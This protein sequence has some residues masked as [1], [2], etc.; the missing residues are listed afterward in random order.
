MVQNATFMIPAS[1]FWPLISLMALLLYMSFITFGGTA[2]GD[3]RK[4]RLGG[5]A[6]Y[7][8]N[9]GI[10]GFFAASIPSSS[11]EYHDLTAHSDSSDG[12]N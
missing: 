9:R 5:R 3:A 2:L 6:A 4:P 1:Y 8:H 11:H 10:G 7:W 12:T